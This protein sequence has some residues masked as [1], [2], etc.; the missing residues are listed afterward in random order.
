MAMLRSPEMTGL[1]RCISSRNASPA[2]APR[3]QQSTSRSRN[4]TAG[5]VANPLDIDMIRRRI[6]TA[7]VALALSLIAE[8]AA[9][10]SVP[11]D[12]AV[13]QRIWSVG[14]DSSRI[15]SLASTLLDSIGPRLTGS[16]GLRA[17]QSWLVDTYKR[18]GIDARN[19]RYGTWRGWRRGH[20]HVD[21]L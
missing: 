17:A 8:P 16:A 20:S 2:P 7:A 14:M 4:S 9:A 3:S 6:T 21:L 12:D 5:P 1:I 13:L 10:Q 15:E 11:T 19:E 18:W